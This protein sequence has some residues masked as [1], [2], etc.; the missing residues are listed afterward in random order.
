MQ[1]RKIKLKVYA[2][3]NLSLNILGSKNCMHELDM[4]LTSIDIADVISVCERYDDKINVEFAGGK[5]IENNTAL[6]AAAVL[7]ERFGDIGA[8]IFIEKAIPFGA[9]LGGSSA[10]AAG[11]I[12]AF[13]KIFGL[14]EKGLRIE[15]AALYVG[16]D[17]PYMLK[18]GFGR[19]KSTGETVEFFDL[20]SELNIVICK[21]KTG[22]STKE[23][24]QKFDEI[25][26][27]KKLIL[28]DN[29]K[30]ISA[31]KTGEIKTA[32]KQFSNA[33]FKG[34]CNLNGSVLKTFEKLEN[35]NPLK[36]MMTGSGSAC[37]AV[38][39]TFS[40]ALTA[41]KILREQNLF[42]VAVKSKPYGIEEI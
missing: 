38:Y 13:D 2:K 23:S 30:L 35:T 40:Q 10:D 5:V 20:T 24:Y 33:L 4:V 16:S 39:D 25:Y 32:A 17:V 22:V 41:A 37:I 1:R 14:S 12:Y 9:G 11:V 31:L 3:V 19:V 34:S 28:S 8:D 26:P 15:E 27:S 29:D 36:T 7:R 18:G 21:D 42:A 6:K